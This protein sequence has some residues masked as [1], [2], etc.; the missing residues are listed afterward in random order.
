MRTSNH[1]AWMSALKWVPSLWYV[2][3]HLCPLLTLATQSHTCHRMLLGWRL[4]VTILMREMML[5]PLWARCTWMWWMFFGYKPLWQFLWVYCYYFADNSYCVGFFSVGYSRVVWSSYQVRWDV[6][7]SCLHTLCVL[8]DIQMFEFII[9]HK[10]FLL[11]VKTNK[12]QTPLV[13]WRKWWTLFWKKR[14]KNE[15][16]N[17]K[18]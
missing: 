13:S 10:L 7:C 6:A 1:C 15:Q 3:G 12:S 4:L 17:K 16:S 5:M 11:A 9:V 8:R 18:R 14:E 2:A